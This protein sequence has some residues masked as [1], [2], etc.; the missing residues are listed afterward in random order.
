M[1]RRGG[2]KMI[3][4]YDYVAVVSPYE[5]TP[6]EGTIKCLNVGFFQDRYE[7]YYSMDP[8]ELVKKYEARC[9]DAG[10]EGLSS[11]EAARVIS[12]S[13]IISMIKQDLIVKLITIDRGLG[14]I[15]SREFDMGRGIRNFAGD[16]Q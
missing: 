2:S 12:K 13:G 4:G 14:L 11:S 3:K 10:I 15:D 6:E 16:T 1:R 7:H 5:C 8:S 9:K